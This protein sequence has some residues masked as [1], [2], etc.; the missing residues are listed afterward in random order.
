MYICGH[1]GALEKVFGC[2]R[3]CENNDNNCDLLY[4]D[5]HKTLGDLRSKE[6]ISVQC[7]GVINY[8]V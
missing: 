3:V 4:F 7:R 8:S 6:P 2:L 1:V 5:D